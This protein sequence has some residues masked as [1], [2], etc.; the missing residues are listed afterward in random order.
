MSMD[1]I[2]MS[3][4]KLSDNSITI[5]FIHLRNC[6]ETFSFKLC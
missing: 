1:Q 6:L 4:H 3:Q 2:I 5:I